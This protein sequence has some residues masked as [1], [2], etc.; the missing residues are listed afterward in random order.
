MTK[1]AQRTADLQHRLAALEDLP[2]L[3]MDLSWGLKNGFF[4]NLDV[5]RG[6]PLRDLCLWGCTEARNY[7]VLADIKTLENLQLPAGYRNLPAKDYE[8]IGALRETLPRV[9]RPLQELRIVGVPQQ[10]AVQLGLEASRGDAGR[11]AG[12]HTAGLVQG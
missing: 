12:H 8:A 2:S 11:H 3:S 10:V 5:L 1:D 6:K 7:A 4:P 9:T